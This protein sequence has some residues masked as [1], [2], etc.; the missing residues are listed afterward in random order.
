MSLQKKPGVSQSKSFC[1]PHPRALNKLT[2]LVALCT[3]QSVVGSHSRAGQCCVRAERVSARAAWLLS[4]P[5]AV[6]HLHPTTAPLLLASGGQCWLHVCAHCARHGRADNRH[7]SVLLPRAGDGI[8][9]STECAGIQR[10]AA[11][12]ACQHRCGTASGP[13]GAATSFCSS[14]F[15]A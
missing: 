10:V 14:V 11:C 6:A 7:A 3:L 4:C 9:G 8:T 1:T 13:A 15:H 5:E 2:E 12:K